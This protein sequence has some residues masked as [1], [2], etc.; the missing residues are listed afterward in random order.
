MSSLT[1]IPQ[2]WTSTSQP[3]K[4]W[5]ADGINVICL[6][7]LILIFSVDLAIPLGIAVGGLYVVVVLLSILSPHAKITLFVAAGSSVFTIGAFI[8]KYSAAEGWKAS[9]NRGLALVV[10]WVTALLIVRVKA[11]QKQ[12]VEMAI[13]DFLTDLLTRREMFGRLSREIVRANRLHKPLS[14]MMIDIDHFKK[15]NDTYGHITGDLV[16]KEMAQRL[17]GTIRKYDFIGRYGGEEFLVATPE[18]AVHPAQ[19]LA[20]R[21]R[22]VIMTAPFQIPP[23]AV[24]TVTTSIGVTQLVEGETVE[25]LVARADAALYKAKESGRNRVV[26]L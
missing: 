10:I 16:L 23:P 13:H 18:I 5:F 7:L 26:V 14:I 20:E 3:A 21:L 15:I 6:L 22:R 2:G 25:Q 8:Y 12:L 11:V 1:A 17:R 24:I 9:V 19:E 4:P